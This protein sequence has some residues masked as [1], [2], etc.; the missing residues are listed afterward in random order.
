[1]VLEREAGGFK[2]WGVGVQVVSWFLL[3]FF[4]GFLEE[5]GD[6]VV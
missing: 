5:E 1:V 6:G 3:G 2:R 4:L